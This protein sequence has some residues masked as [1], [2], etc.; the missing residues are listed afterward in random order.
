MI[1]NELLK[2]ISEIV[3]QMSDTYEEIRTK[4]NIT[5]QMNTMHNVIKNTY[6]NLVNYS[7]SF[8][9]DIND[10]DD[11]LLLYTY[12]D[13]DNN[14][15]RELNEYLRDNERNINKLRKIFDIINNKSTDNIIRKLAEKNKI[16]DNFNSKKINK[17]NNENNNNEYLASTNTL[18]NKINYNKPH[19]TKFNKSF[20]FKN[21][22]KNLYSKKLR[23]LSIHSEQGSISTSLL[24]KESK[25]LIKTL[26]NFN[27]TYLSTEF[28]QI[29]PIG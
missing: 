14:N 29:K 16:E 21:S 23:K 3:D 25:K 19:K 9:K 11:I 10:Y 28:L 12:I 6:D 5:E 22:N 15:L 7:Q 27:K 4:Y 20:S 1:Q 2:K 8:I 24:I 26:N 18:N 13:W 17:N